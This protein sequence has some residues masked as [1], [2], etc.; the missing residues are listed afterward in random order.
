MLYAMI[1]ADGAFF[2][3]FLADFIDIKGPA[4]DALTKTNNARP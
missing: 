4:V 2:G 1:G 3:E